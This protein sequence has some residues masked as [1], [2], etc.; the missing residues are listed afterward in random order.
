MNWREDQAKKYAQFERDINRA[1]AKLSKQKSCE[2]FGDK[3]IRAIKDKWSDYLH[4]NWQVVKPFVE[5][6]NSFETWCGNYINY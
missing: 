2:N 6:L 4:G 1:V 5:R 3:E